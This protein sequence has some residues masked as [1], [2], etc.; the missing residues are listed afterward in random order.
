MRMNRGLIVSSV[1]VLVTA[2]VVSGCTTHRLLDRGIGS[3]VDA[4][5]EQVGQAVGEA[6]V[7]EYSPQFTR[8]YTSYL[9]EMAFYAGGESVEGVTREYAPG[10]YTQWL[11]SG[12][13]AEEINRMR[14]AYLGDDADGNQWWQI[15]YE[16]SASEDTII[17]EALF[18]PDREQMLRLRTLFPDE[19]Q[20]QERPVEDQR[21]HEPH[22]VTQ[23]SL[24]AAVEE[25][26]EVSVPAGTFQ[27][28]RAAF[29]ASAEGRRVWWLS[30]DVPG[31]VVRYALEQPEAEEDAP[32][33][34]EDIP[35]EAYVSEL[36]EYGSDAETRLDTEI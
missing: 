10:E 21:Y 11:V 15:V 6:I 32:E 30:D 34:A 31:G 14:R 27:T 18:T 26:T 8:W 33:D 36:E 12:E 22:K 28:R 7:R 1:T 2:L 24:D 19:D 4:A 25:E 20:P 5:G 23:E 9:M 29:G 16:D 17:M 13:D 3:A 35:L